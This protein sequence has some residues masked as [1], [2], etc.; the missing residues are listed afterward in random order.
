VTYNATAALPYIDPERAVSGLKGQLRL[1]AGQD[2]TVPDWNTLRVFGPD[3]VVGQHSR[4]W[5]EWTAAVDAQDA[6]PQAHVRCDR[7]P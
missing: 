2:N 4:V 1:I 7:Q 3:E 6:A 5:Y